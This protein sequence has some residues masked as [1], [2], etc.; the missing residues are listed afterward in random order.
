MRQSRDRGGRTLL[1]I[2]FLENCMIKDI[3]LNI[4]QDAV[5]DHASD[6]AMSIAEQ[7]DSHIAGIAFAYT[8]SHR[9]VR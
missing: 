6:F 5:R 4:E 3:I 7:F 8:S 9:T 1:I 2:G